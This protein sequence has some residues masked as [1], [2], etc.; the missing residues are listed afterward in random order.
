MGFPLRNKLAS[1][2]I[3]IPGHVHVDQASSSSPVVMAAPRGPT[4]KVSLSFRGFTPRETHGEYPE[5]NFVLRIWHPGFL[6]FGLV[7]HYD[8][9]KANHVHQFV[10]MPEFTFRRPRPSAYDAKKGELR[11][12]YD[13]A[14][15]LTLMVQ[16]E[17]DAGQDCVKEGGSYRH[18]MLRDVHV[19]N[20]TGHGIDKRYPNVQFVSECL[21][22]MRVPG[23][24]DCFSDGIKAT[25]VEM[26]VQCT[27]DGAVPK[28]VP[29]AYGPLSVGHFDSRARG[30]LHAFTRELLAFHETVPVNVNKARK[31]Y[32]LQYKIAEG[33]AIPASAYMLHM[34][35]ADSIPPS[36]RVVRAFFLAALSVHPEFFSKPRP[37]LSAQETAVQNWI[38]ACEAWLGSDTAPREGDP[39]VN[40]TLLDCMR[41]A[42]TVLTVY[43][44]SV[45]YIL[46]M[47]VDTYG[48]LKGRPTPFAHAME[49]DEDDGEVYDE[50]YSLAEPVE[51]FSCAAMCNAGTDCE[52]YGMFA[53]W[54]KNMIQRT[55]ASSSDSLLRTLARVYELF[56]GCVPH[57]DC[58]GD[59]TQLEKDDGV[60]HYAMYMFPR[61]YMEACWLRSG[62]SVNLFAERTKFARSWEADYKKHLGVFLIEG[63]NT[64]D[65][66]QFRTPAYYEG[67]RETNT[68]KAS[69]G[70]RAV[71]DAASKRRMNVYHSYVFGRGGQLSGFYRWACS[72]FCEETSRNNVLDFAFM[73]HDVKCVRVE[74]IA[75][76]SDAVSVQQ[77]ARYEPATLALCHEIID[78]YQPPYRG[79]DEAPVETDPDL[80]KKI[81]ALSPVLR[82]MLLASPPEEMAARRRN[83]RVQL[84]DHDLS[85]QRGSR[86]KEL[87]RALEEFAAGMNATGVQIFANVLG[88]TWAMPCD[89]T[90]ARTGTNYLVVQLCVIFYY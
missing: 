43:P 76:M 39:S 90:L 51:N 48:K 40:I 52:D 85:E 12:P 22:G 41:V 63:T 72:M 34:M 73:E 75:E 82:R 81:L 45:P 29:S 35:A 47:E 65:A 70:M 71:Q 68:T 31:Y 18:V 77:I 59:D 69:A 14:L 58:K 3:Y 7:S 60:Y 28:F 23:T 61:R 8:L 53:Y 56:V 42:T 5:K 83:V 50:A 25:A 46:D 66:A 16:T 79:L 15:G 84:Q 19:N 54:L 6:D 78:L 13:A 2:L 32:S 26:R 74:R 21:E 67:I 89:M 33:V 80:V 30:M 20:T 38:A 24:S 11:L 1:I 62:A 37:P 55:Y 9:M 57:M 87:V 49:G 27:L 4:C 44:N 86:T 88:G 64:V 36:P 10:S 17:N